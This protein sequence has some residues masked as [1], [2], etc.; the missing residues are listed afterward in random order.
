MA[1]TTVNLSA[2]MFDKVNAVI[3]AARNLPDLIAR[4]KV[5]DPDLAEQLEGKLLIQAKSPVVVT[6]SGLISWL[7]ARYGLG[8]DPDTTSAVAG[9]IVLAAGYGMRYVTHA[10][11]AGILHKPHFPPSPYVH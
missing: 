6:L 10:P 9:V 7:V 8:W 3:A 2:S 11:I 1:Q 4:F 5:L